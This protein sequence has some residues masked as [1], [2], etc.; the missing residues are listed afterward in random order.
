MG[1]QPPASE[2]SLNASTDTYCFSIVLPLVLPILEFPHPWPAPLLIYV[3]CLVWWHRL[4]LIS[5]KSAAPF[6]S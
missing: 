6:L 2:A 4:L 3:A 1:I 5:L